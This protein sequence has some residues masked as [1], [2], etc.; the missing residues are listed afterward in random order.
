MSDERVLNIFPK[1]S[2]IDVWLLGNSNRNPGFPIQNLPSY[3]RSEV[4]FRHFGCLR[5]GISP[6]QSEMCGWPSEWISESS[7]QSRHSTASFVVYLVCIVLCTLGEKNT[8]T[9]WW[10][11]Y[12]HVP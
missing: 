12:H 4:R 6:I 10:A 2:E 7:H 1:L 5:V 9:S 8:T 11:G 3:S